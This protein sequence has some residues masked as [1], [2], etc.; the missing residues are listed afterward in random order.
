MTS[1]TRDEI[2]QAVRDAF[3]ELESTV[4]REEFQK[5]GREFQKIDYQFQK[6]DHEFQRVNHHLAE[7]DRRFDEQD[8]R[9]ITIDRHLTEHDRRFDEHDLCLTGHDRHFTE[10]NC[11]FENIETFMR[12]SKVIHL[13]QVIHP[14][15]V[16]DPSNQ[17]A[18][19]I[20]NGFS[21]TALKLYNLQEKKNWR[22]L[23]DLLVY[24][25]LGS[26]LLQL[27]QPQDIPS[28]DDSDSDS[29]P[30]SKK[31]ITEIELRN[32][33]E[34]NPWAAV[35]ALGSRLGVD[36]DALHDRVTQL[37]FQQK[38]GMKVKRSLPAR[39]SP[40]IEE[41]LRISLP[42]RC[43]PSRE[44]SILRR[45]VHHAQLG[46]QFCKIQR[47]LCYQYQTPSNFGCS[48]RCG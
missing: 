26:E 31:K 28:S 7:H 13:N 33:I 43:L 40:N 45:E 21:T 22:K 3:T 19:S 46:S 11:R 32:A 25:D 41:E 38:R 6:I 30:T 34:S 48:R 1:I 29:D 10:H 47:V 9:L 39:S 27:T 2:R 37:E 4:W 23:K 35:V 16:R 14:L 12:N 18:L 8:R 15:Y 17:Q 5:I 44:K 42:A 20:P 24:Y 36:C